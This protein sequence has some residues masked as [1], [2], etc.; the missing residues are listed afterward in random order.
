MP[1]VRAFDFSN[2]QPTSE[3]PVPEAPW[4]RPTYLSYGQMISWVAILRDW[5]FDRIYFDMLFK[6]NIDG[7]LAGKLCKRTSIIDWIPVRFGKC[8][9]PTVSSHLEEVGRWPLWAV[10]ICIL[11][12]F[13]VVAVATLTFSLWTASHTRSM[14]LVNILLLLLKWT[15]MKPLIY[16][17]GQQYH[18]HH[19][20]VSKRGRSKNISFYF[21]QACLSRMKSNFIAVILL[22]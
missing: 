14:A 4:A 2:F 5:N 13:Q 20:K 15:T 16:K 12:P 17:L 3:M 9:R 22:G 11:F 18:H 7:F 1:L 8:S 10:N 6:T 19:L 21:S